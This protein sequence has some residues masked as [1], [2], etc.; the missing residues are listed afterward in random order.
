MAKKNVSVS[1]NEFDFKL[2]TKQLVGLTLLTAI[3]YVIF[4]IFSDGFYQHDEAAHFINMRTFWYNPNIILGNWAKPGYKLL[5]VIPSLGGTFAVVMVNSLFSAFTAFFAYKIAQI[6]RFK[7]AGLAFFLMAT[8]PMWLQLSFRNYSEIPTAFLISLAIWLFYS[9]KTVAQKLGISEE[10]KS[11]RLIYVSLILSYLTLLRQEFY[12]VGFIYVLWLGFTKQLKWIP[13]VAVFPILI[14]IWG[15]LATDDPYYLISSTFGT[16]ESYKNAY[17][18]QGFDHYF[19]MLTFITGP[20]VILGTLVSLFEIIKK[21]IVYLMPIVIVALI[22]L[23]LHA[24]F[25]LQAFTIGASTGG[26]LR[27]MLV[28]SPM[29]AVLALFGINHIKSSAKISGSSWAI[30]GLYVAVVAIFLSFKN[31]NIV[32]TPERDWAPFFAVLGFSLVLVFLSKSKQ[33][34]IGLVLLQVLFLLGTEKPYKRTL[35]DSTVE[36][37]VN[38]AEKN[39]LFDKPTLMQ[40]TLFYY[41]T[42]KVSQEFKNGNGTLIT[43]ETIAE[44]KPGTVIFWDSHYSYRPNLRPTSVPYTYFTERP[45]EFKVL[46]QFISPDQRFGVFVFEKL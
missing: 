3:G 1:E 44:A 46:G 42:G 16:A 35:A 15:W 23:L 19:I 18:R 27:Y 2:S 4:S 33:W 12:V 37:V 36:Q 25:N 39:N 11:N 14:H 22:Y 8:Q 32:L 5:M 26:N 6:L 43:Q 21:K 24:L 34:L 31:N 13:L 28:I 30:M 17:P 7:N 9:D 20:L 45:N 40:H 10:S 29:L 38:W 41:F